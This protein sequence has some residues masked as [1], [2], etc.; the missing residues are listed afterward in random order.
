M[1]WLSA[2]RIGQ[3]P[4]P[5]KQHARL[6]TGTFKLINLIFK[7]LSQIDDPGYAS[8]R[9]VA[10]G[11]IYK[12]GNGTTLGVPPSQ[13]VFVVANEGLGWNPLLNI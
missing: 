3:R 6:L 12:P 13:E 9:L 7:D 10:G 5:R 1:C 11:V 4:Q 2:F 8:E